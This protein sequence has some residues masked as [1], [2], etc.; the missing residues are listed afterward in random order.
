[1]LLIVFVYLTVQKQDKFV[2]IVSII[3]EEMFGSFQT[4]LKYSRAVL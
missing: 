3:F 2:E 4:H 1:M